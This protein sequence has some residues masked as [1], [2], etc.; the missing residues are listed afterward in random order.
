[1]IADWIDAE[2][3]GIDREM[4]VG[5]EWQLKRQRIDWAALSSA[6]CMWLLCNYCRSSVSTVLLHYMKDSY[7]LCLEGVILSL[8]YTISGIKESKS[9]PAYVLNNI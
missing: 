2:S 7:L 6:C 8:T 3:Q 4:E 9:I 1:M 5:I